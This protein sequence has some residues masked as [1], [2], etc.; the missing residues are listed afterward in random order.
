MSLRQTWGL[1]LERCISGGPYRFSRNPQ[2]L[3]VFAVLLG[4]AMLGRSGAALALVAVYWLAS[5]AW[6]R[7]EEH[8]MRERFGDGYDVYC[9]K[10]PRF[11]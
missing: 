8:L 5:V 1:E 10:V 2:L 6:V 9:S 11:L 7:L 3:G 4:A